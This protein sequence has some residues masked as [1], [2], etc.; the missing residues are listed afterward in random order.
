MKYRGLVGRGDLVPEV[1]RALGI[2]PWDPDWTASL[3]RALG[4]EGKAPMTA[5][6]LHSGGPPARH[7]ASG[8]RTAT[9]ATAGHLWCGGD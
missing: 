6:E 3:R 7:L 4:I 8:Q 9:P 2:K 1:Y 5:D